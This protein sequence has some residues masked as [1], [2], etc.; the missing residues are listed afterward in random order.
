MFQSTSWTRASPIQ[1]RR[2]HAPTTSPTTAPTLC[3]RASVSCAASA[4]KSSP[5]RTTISSA[6][7]AETPV[8]SSSIA[9]PPP[10]SSLLN[11]LSKLSGTTNISIK[12][13]LPNEDLDALITVTADEDVENM[14][15]EYDRLSQGHKSARLRVFLFPTDNSDISR[16]TSINSILDGSVKR[17]NWFVDAL[18]GGQGGG[19]VLDRGRSEVSSIVSEVPDYLFGL[20]NSDDALK[21]GTKIRNKNILNDNVSMSDP[22]SPAPI[23]SSPFCSTSSS[24]A[25]SS[26]QVIPD[27]PPV[28]TRPVNTVQVVSEMVNEKMVP[29]STGY[30]GSPMWQYANPAVQPMPAVYYMP[31]SHVQPGNAPV[32]P[33][34]I[35]AQFV[36]PYTVGPGQVPIGFPGVNQ[37]YGAGVRPYEMPA[38]IITDNTGQAMYYGARN[39]AVVPGSYPGMVVSGGEEMHGSGPDVIPEEENGE[40]KPWKL[41]PRKEVIKAASTCKNETGAENNDNKINS[42]SNVVKSQRLR[43]LVE[44]GQQ[45]GGVE[46]KGK[47]R[48]WISLS[49][50]EIEEDI[51]ALTG[52]KPARR[53]KKWP[54][55]VQKQL[56]V[57]GL[58]IPPHPLLRWSSLVFMHYGVLGLST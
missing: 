12:Y 16:S 19:P 21:E 11:K 53:P 2:P 28:R 41:R 22:G 31:G 34:Q 35:R 20:D 48:V 17:E 36:Q 42:N 7:S 27:L 25:P 6:T 50:E 24:L 51:Y 1:S 37:V 44:G 29:Q 14:M 49:R 54:K 15:E 40:A 33:V 30:S 38:R 46:R 8:S 32:Q 9:T 5:A 26:L 58:E 18:N 43:G 45:N 47:R 39:M 23:V 4:E 10:F 57:R 56:D 52:G 55:N 13:Q 3:S